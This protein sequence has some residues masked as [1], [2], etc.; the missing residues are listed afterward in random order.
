M[1]LV[2]Y[3]PES[4]YTYYQT[5]SQYM[6]PMYQQLQPHQTLQVQSQTHQ[7]PVYCANC[8]GIGH[9]YKSCNHP[10]TS[11]G[12]ICYKLF[13]DQETNTISPKYLMVQRKD[14]LS[15]VEFIRGKYDINNIKYLCQ[16]FSN[17]T[18][19][20]RKKIET[21]EFEILWK[22]M[23][24]KSINQERNKNFNKEYND[25]KMRFDMLKRGI[26]VNSKTKGQILFG[27]KYI[28]DN[29]QANYNETEWGFPK[30]RRNI[31]EDDITCALREFREETNINTRSI[32]VLHD[33]KPLEE[34][35]SGTNNIRYKHVYY[36]AR[37]VSH[38][39]E[40]PS[41]ANN[42]E[43]KSIDWFDYNS[44]QEKIRDFNVERKELFKRLNQLI[45]KNISK[46]MRH[47]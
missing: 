8:G 18:S 46:M 25:S 26:Y 35:F 15:Y 20:E 33:I 16:L 41:T 29:T 21:Q 27:F 43:I 31:N 37:Y 22:E 11:Y 17:M 12:I 28:M 30:G 42:I 3:P 4:Y 45:M 19:D 38:Y 2:D 47:V 7:N 40:L 36:I 9:I 10:I 39:D 13:Y 14:S 32:K 6:T 24:C 23:W 1:L 44:A 5:Q 34:V